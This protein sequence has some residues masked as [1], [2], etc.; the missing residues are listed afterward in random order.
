MENQNEIEKKENAEDEISLLDLFAV[1]IR[2]R[3]LIIF[4]TLIVSF[5]AGLYLFIVPLFVKKLDVKTAT[6]TYTVDV[7]PIPSIMAAKL[8]SPS[9]LY[10]S[11]YNAQ[12][13]PFLVD[14]IKKNNIFSDENEMSDY[15]FNKF[16]QTIKKDG[17]IKINTSSLGNGYD[18]VLEIPLEKIDDSRSFV[19]SIVAD[20]EVELQNYILPLIATLDQNTNLSIE[21]ATLIATSVSDM[22]ALQALQDLSVAIDDFTET[23]D[24]FLTLR[25][26]P[27]VVPEGRGRAKKFIIVFF[28]SFFIFVFAAFC[29]NAVLNIKADPESRKLISDAWNAGK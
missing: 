22:S 21:K 23:F 9:P 13:L 11:T 7:K 10:L 8:S 18:I 1:L 26:E 29:K 25:E 5:I 28:A 6:V 24:Q 19:K 15:D 12:R 27:F 20:T 3:K 16:V 14:E 17:K 4:G 2:N